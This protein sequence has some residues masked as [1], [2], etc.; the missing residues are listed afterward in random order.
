MTYA[1]LGVFLI[2]LQAPH[3]I[4]PVADEVERIFH[5]TWMYV[6]H[7]SE[8]PEPGDYVVRQVAL[9]NG[10]DDDAV[11]EQRRREVGAEH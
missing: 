7:A 9:G 6:A 1:G 4:H 10:G 2:F 8:V 3:E 5:R 11:P